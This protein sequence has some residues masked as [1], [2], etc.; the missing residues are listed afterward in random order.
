MVI[1]PQMTEYVL[2]QLDACDAADVAALQHILEAEP[3]Y[4]V[5][6]SGAL[7]SSSAAQEMFEALPPAKSAADKFVFEIRS[8]AGAIGCVDF[9]RGYPEARTA[10]IGLL[11]L[12]ETAQGQSH[13]P[14]VLR[15]LE[16]MATE[17]GCSVMRIAVIETNT[18]A[19]AFWRREG[20]VELY[21]KA[22]A[23]FTGAAI[24]MERAVG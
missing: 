5:T 20:F 17:W 14:Q 9:V 21:R 13:G 22:S 2:R 3:A 6:V 12:V 4:G 15:L 11:L 8:Q 16:A 23:G 18:R 19:L 1:Y 7:P 10:F 24:V